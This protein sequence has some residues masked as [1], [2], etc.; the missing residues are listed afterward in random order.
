M[1]AGVP[2]VSELTDYLLEFATGAAG[3]VGVSGAVLSKTVVVTGPALA[4]ACA[5]FLARRLGLP[6]SASVASGVVYGLNPVVLNKVDSGQLSF[7]FGYALFP[8]P[9]AAFEGACRSRRPWLGGMATGAALALATIQI[10]LGFIAV[11]LVAFAALVLA[12]GDRRLRCLTFIVALATLVVVE[13]PVI[14]GFL[15]NIA[16]LEGLRTGF[17]H[18]ASWISSNSALPTEALK[19]AGYIVR[20]DLDA[21]RSWY[22]EWSV[23][24][25]A[26]AFFALAGLLVAPVRLRVW[27]L[28]TGFAALFVVTGAYSPFS[29]AILW[30][31]A[32]VSL[33]QAFLEL[34]DVMA[35]L[36]LV[37]SIGIGVCWAA[38]RGRFGIALKSAIAVA[39]VAFV[40]PMLSG[41]GGGLLR[42]FPYD[43]EMA[44]AYA[45]VAGES[46]RVVWFPM[47]QPLSF[48]G[49]GAGVEP[50]WMTAPGSL[51]KYSLA[52][53]LSAVDMN[54]RVGDWNGLRSGLES[55]SVGSVVERRDFESQLYRFLLGP[56]KHTYLQ[57]PVQV[58]PLSDRSQYV[59]ATTRIDTLD[60]ALPIAYGD[61]GVAVVPRRLGVI[62]TFARTALVP[63]SFAPGIPRD[64]PYVVMRDRD[65]RV[66]EDEHWR[67]SRPYRWPPSILA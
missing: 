23:A 17:R 64:V 26:V 19:L 59:G 44:A 18:D 22:V 14:V 6:L 31:F 29:G 57:R 46:R 54:A 60:H 16:P 20:Y 43:G 52:W 28:V 8:L 30:L 25:Y 47:D 12:T 56:R 4:C 15:S 48:R 21:V 39:V 7:I 13:V 40:A 3:F 1:D 42:A 51:W 32:H 27:G 62:G 33:S 36:A 24:A 9:L 67:A 41:N 5:M 37:Y 45:K 35:T 61:D 50:M 34:Y 55:L 66:D 10:Q 63:V 49:Q 58:P 65:D 38:A 53:P 2:G 11:L